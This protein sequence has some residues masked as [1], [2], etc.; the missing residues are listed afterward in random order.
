MSGTDRDQRA[1][2]HSGKSC[3]DSING[4]CPWCKTGDQK[5]PPRRAVRRDGKILARKEERS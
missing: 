2:P 1:R 4:G 3:P 5:L